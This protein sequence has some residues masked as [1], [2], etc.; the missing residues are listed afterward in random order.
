VRLNT[1]LPTIKPL[2]RAGVSVSAHPAADFSARNATASKSN[3]LAML[4]R[5]VASRPAAISREAGESPEDTTTR[6]TG[7][8]EVSNGLAGM[9]NRLPCA[10]PHP[11]DG[12]PDPPRGREGRAA[13][14]TKSRTA[15]RAARKRSSSPLSSTERIRQWDRDNLI[16]GR[17]VSKRYKRPLATGGLRHVVNYAFLAL[18][19]AVQHVQIVPL[20]AA[21]NAREGLRD[22]I[23]QRRAYG[24]TTNRKLVGTGN[25]LEGGSIMKSDY[26]ELRYFVPG[27]DRDALD[28]HSDAM[29]DALLVEPNLTDP[30]R[31]TTSSSQSRIRHPTKRRCRARFYRLTV[32]TA[33]I[34]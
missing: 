20:T 10:F 16:I 29:M 31:I 23:L 32:S 18:L 21:A 9:G 34:M 33:R 11:E 6:R 8:Q 15:R 24:H 3:V 25:V 26:V 17:S 4:P 19:N 5:K 30:D 7:W 13:K 22:Q 12:R 1:S 14:G 27:A 2:S 28:R